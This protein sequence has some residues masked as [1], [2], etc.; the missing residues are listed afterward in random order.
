MALLSESVD[1]QPIK[2]SGSCVKHPLSCGCR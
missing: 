1:A 2:A